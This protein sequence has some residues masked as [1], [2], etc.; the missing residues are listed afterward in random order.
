MSKRVGRLRERARRKD[1]V[2]WGLL[3]SHDNPAWPWLSHNITHPTPVGIIR[4]PCTVDIIT[5]SLGCVVPTSI[6]G[7][8]SKSDIGVVGAVD[9]AQG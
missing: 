5:S 7:D 6:G 1:S 8:R 9:G 4:F 2:R 3:S